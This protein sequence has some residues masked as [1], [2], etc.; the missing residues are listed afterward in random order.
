MRAVKGCDFV[1]DDGPERVDVKSYLV[2][3]ISAAAPANSLI[4]MSSSLAGM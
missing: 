2:A 1:Q 4:A 3:R